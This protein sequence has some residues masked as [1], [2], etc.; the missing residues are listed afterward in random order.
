MQR[1]YKSTEEIF[2]F[3]DRKCK[4]FCLKQGISIDKCISEF[5]S[6]LNFKRKGF[7][8]LLN[9][10]I[11]GR[12]DRLIVYYKD[13]LCRFGFEMFEELSKKYNFKI[14]VVDNTE[15]K[16]RDKEFA[17]D[18][19]AIIHFFSMRLYGSRNY[20]KNL[21]DAEESIQKAKEEI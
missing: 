6:G 20:K 13:R 12:I 19:I 10:A 1:I 3:T 18:I 5:G 15:T 11:N 14:I 9:L 7:L 21:K 2:R 16:S 4:Q 17:D 8:E